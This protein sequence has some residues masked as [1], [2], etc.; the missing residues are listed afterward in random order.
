MSEIFWVPLLIS[1]NNK[2]KAH[3]I[4]DY[5]MTDLECDVDDCL[6]GLSLTQTHSSPEQVTILTQKMHRGRQYEPPELRTLAREPGDKT[7]PL[8]VIVE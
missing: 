3:A 8:C 5:H 1:L 6:Y 2:L 4:Y 7:P